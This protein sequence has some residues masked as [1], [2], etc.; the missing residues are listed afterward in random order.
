[1]K[2]GATRGDRIAITEGLREGERVVAA[3]QIKLQAYMPVTLDQTASL[4]PQAETPRP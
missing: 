4:P 2:V 3:G 1:M